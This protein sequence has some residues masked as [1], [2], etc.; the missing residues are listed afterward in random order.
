MN[1]PRAAVAGSQASARPGDRW[2]HDAQPDE[3]VTATI[4]LRSAAG[5]VGQQLLSGQYR[6][7]SREEAEQSLAATPGQLDSIREFAKQYGLTVVHEQP[8]SRRV[9]LR[10]TAAQMEQAFGVKLGVAENQ[11]GHKFQTYQGS[12]TLPASLAGMVTAVLGFDQRP[13]AHHAGS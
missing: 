9:R 1:E 10:G 12:I 4:I 8:V 11:S 5:D 3:S 13:I 2:V 6:P 7:A